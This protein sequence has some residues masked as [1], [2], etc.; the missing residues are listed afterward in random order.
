[1]GRLFVLHRVGT[2]SLGIGWYFLGIGWSSSEL[3]FAVSRKD[4]RKK[5]VD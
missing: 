4:K 3:V 2:L 5:E 1:M